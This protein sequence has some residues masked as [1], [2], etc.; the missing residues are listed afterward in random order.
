VLQPGIQ[1]VTSRTLR[2]YI[3]SPKLRKNVI[4]RTLKKMLLPEK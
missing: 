3:A 4:S 1:D 2:K